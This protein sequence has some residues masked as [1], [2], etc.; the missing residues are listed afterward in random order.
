MNKMGKK[1]MIFTLKLESFYICMK[2]TFSAYKIQYYSSL[3]LAIIGSTL[4]TI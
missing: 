1:E 2:V 3:N 4:D